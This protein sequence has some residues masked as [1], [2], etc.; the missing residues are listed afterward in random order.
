MSRG[1]KEFITK[2]IAIFIEQTTT[3]LDK[4]TIAMRQDDFLEVSRLI[5]KIRP[6]VESLGIAS[7]ISEMKLLEKIA[8]EAK[9][10]QQISTL[11][12]IIK[13]VLENI[14]LQLQEENT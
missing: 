14:V 5:H 3:T 1:N 7:I 9:D 2:M 13:D 4:A 12:D 10:K 8:Q 11:F 6:S